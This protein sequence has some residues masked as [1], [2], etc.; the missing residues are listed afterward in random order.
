[1][2]IIILLILLSNIFAQISY[3]GMPKYYQRESALDF[4]SPNRENLVDRNF[5]PMVFQFGEE[6]LLDVNVLESV[7]PVYDEDV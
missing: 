2:R 5:H 7:E 1:M 4:I 6:Y 3:G